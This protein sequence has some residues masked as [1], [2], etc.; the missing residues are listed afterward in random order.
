MEGDRT[1]VTLLERRVIPVVVLDDAGAAPALA[2]ALAAG[3][4]PVAEVTFRT[5]QAAE[6]I[7]ALARDTGL[8]VGAGTVVRA[9]LVDRA[10]DAGARFVVSPGFSR[11][12]V[13]RCLD[14]GVPVVPGAVT[15]SEVMAALEYGL[16]FVKFFPAEAAGGVA[17]L[18]A[19][20]APFPGVRFV[21]TGGIT[22]GNAKDYL[23][24]PAVAAIGASWMVAPALL[25]AGDFT[26]VTRR[27][28]AVVALAGG[29]S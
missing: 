8:L 23:E 11:A 17:A 16:E 12:V 6:A 1:L 14:L 15:A 5:A 13:E 24:H 28:A 2:D 29:S 22:A 26:E 4:L 9:E 3:G 25:A 7:A 10:V 27:T 19:L 20:A 21:P 18:G